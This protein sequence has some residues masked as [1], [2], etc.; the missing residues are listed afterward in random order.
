M[1]QV[2]LDLK[3]RVEYEIFR[4]VPVFNKAWKLHEVG[5]NAI[6]RPR[7]RL[8]PPLFV[9]MTYGPR[10]VVGFGDGEDPEDFFLSGREQAGVKAGNL[11]S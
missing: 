3:L 1:V 5:Q 7:P 2:Q 6:A 10:P 9:V 8:Q 4:I 11:I